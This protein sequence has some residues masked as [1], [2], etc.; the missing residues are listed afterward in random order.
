MKSADFDVVVI[1]S[2]FG[3]SVAALRLTEK[4]YKV[5]VLEAGRRFS[6]KDFPKT[7]WRLSRFLYMP[8]LGLRGIQRIH[9]LPDVLVLAGAGV[10]GGS[11]VY[12]NTLYKPP[13]SYFEDKQWKHITNWDSELSPWYDQASRMLGVAENP[14]FSPSD[15][16]MKEVANQMGVG[17]HDRV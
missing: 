7:S 13:A 17:L 10:G 6:D 9:V 16:A 5:A 2:G 1:G 12:A 14:Y 4:G 8:R 3:G 11:L 15:K